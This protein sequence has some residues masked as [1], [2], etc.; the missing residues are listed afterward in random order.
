MSLDNSWIDALALA[1]H[2][3]RLSKAESLYRV[4]AADKALDTCEHLPYLRSVAK[5]N[6]L[7]IGV[8]CG[9]STTALLAGV[10][11]NGGHLWSVD[12]HPACR[13]IWYGHPQW[14][15]CC[16]WTDDKVSPT[17]P[18]DVV[19]IDGDHSYNCVWLDLDAWVPKVRPGGLILCHDAASP[20]FPGVRQAIN[21][22]CAARSLKHELR[23]GSNGLEVIYAAN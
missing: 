18:L 7:E 9:V 1:S 13:Y 17:L 3:P 4:M 15:F 23:P 10:E 21:E 12:V 22:Y 5:G 11:D 8:H 14:T 20:S 2:P 6:I 19:F 16:P